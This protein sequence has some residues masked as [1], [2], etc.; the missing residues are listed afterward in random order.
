M[1]LSEIEIKKE[2]KILLN[3]ENKIK[4]DF[5]SNRDL[6]FFI[7]GIAAKFSTLGSFD[8]VEIRTNINDFIERNFGGI[9]YEIDIL[10]DLKLRDREKEME[11]IKDILKEKILEKKK[12]KKEI[13]RASCRERV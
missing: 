8:E 5:H 13:G 10:L 9:D 6:Y 11:A 7:K 2:Y 12:E 1:D 3:K 4:E